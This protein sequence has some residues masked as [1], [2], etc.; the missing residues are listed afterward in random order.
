MISATTPTISFL[1]K[2]TQLDLQA[3]S[4]IQLTLSSL[5]NELVLNKERM[6]IDNE[7]KRITVTL[8]Q[9]ESRMF[10]SG[11]IKAQFRMKDTAGGINPT[12]IVELK[13]GTTLNDEIL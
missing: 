8:T 10:Q 1:L 3:M 2:N 13:I 12:S 9:E 6:T 5:C 4:K 7:A 11:T